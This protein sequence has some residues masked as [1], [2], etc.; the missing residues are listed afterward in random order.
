MITLFLIAVFLALMLVSVPIAFALGF[1]TMLAFIIPDVPLDL[2]AARLYGGLNRFIF[3]AIPFF[4]L[5]GELMTESGILARLLDFT[6]LLVGKIKGGLYHMN[7]LVSM[8]FGGINGSAIAD[9]ALVGSMLIP[10]TINEYKNREFTAAVTACSSVVGPVIPPSLPMLLYAF[11]AGN[12]SVGGLFMGG[13]VPG[14]ILAGGLM[15]ITWITVRKKDLPRLVFSYSFMGVVKILLRFIIAILLPIIMVGGIVSGIFTP[16]ESGCVAVFYALIVG[17]FITRELTFKKVYQALVRTAIVS[18]VVLFIISCSGV[19]TW[20]LTI[21]NVPDQ[22][23]MSLQAFITGKQMFLLLMVGLL[24]FIGLFVE[25]GAG[26]VLLA[27]ILVPMAESFGVNPIQFGLMTCLGLLIGVVT[28]PVGICLYISSSIAG[29][30]PEKVFKAALP[31][32]A[33]EGA[34]L[35]LI[36][37][38]PEVYLWVPRLFGYKTG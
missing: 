15:L 12:V 24:L 1:S 10:A 25:V 18:G 8:I 5:A 36:T 26:I 27:P 30:P 21:Q 37:F 17:F 11:V 35:L 3:V 38:L 6:R 7:I 13:V 14:M 16:T 29:A 31:L 19:T 23:V 33:L 20:W 22:I 2:M 34:V 32:L 9:T 28:P 4:I